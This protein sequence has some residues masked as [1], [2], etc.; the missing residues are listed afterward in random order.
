MIL[1]LVGEL[2]SRVGRQQAVEECFDRLRRGAPS[3]ADKP[4]TAGK[5]EVVLTGLTDPAKADRKSVV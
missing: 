2:L 1:P 5:C 3:H 4:A